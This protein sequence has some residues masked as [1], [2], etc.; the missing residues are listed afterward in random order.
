LY[1]KRR[2][3]VKYLTAAIWNQKFAE[4]VI[5]FETRTHELSEALSLQIAGDIQDVKKMSVA[6]IS[7]QFS[8]FFFNALTRLEE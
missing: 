5:Q 4:Y 8:E 6:M 7:P 1:Q 3:L 2:P